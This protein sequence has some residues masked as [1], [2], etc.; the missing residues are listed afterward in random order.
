M[1]KPMQS[2][3]SQPGAPLAVLGIHGGPRAGEELA[4]RLPVVRIGQGAQNELVLADDSVSTQHAR[5][6]YESS[7]WLLTDLGSTNG[8]YV[9]GV[10]LA[11]NVPTPL[12]DGS[13]VRFGGISLQ[14]R[15]LETVHADTARASYTPPSA[16]APIAER[17]GGFRLPVWAFVLILIL[18]GALL[19]FVLD[20]P[21]SG[22]L[23]FLGDSSDLQIVFS[24]DS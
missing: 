4:V 18:L 1:T 17:K 15:Q 21:G 6:G 22:T 2:A 12:T 16:P 20:G 14:F 24:V 5:L 8:T 23:G 19:F 10:R 9:E 13:L 7:R 3:P 11:P